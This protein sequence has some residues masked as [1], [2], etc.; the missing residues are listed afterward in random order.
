[1]KKWTR[2]HR[3][4]TW[5]RLFMAVYMLATGSETLQVRLYC[6]LIHILPLHVDE[7]PEELQTN[8]K[9]LRSYTDKALIYSM[10]DDEA[11]KVAEQILSMYDVVAR[12]YCLPKTLT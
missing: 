7:F 10:P 4:T 3:D 5:E 8:A 11:S 9:L 2:A 6:A 1:M 12:D